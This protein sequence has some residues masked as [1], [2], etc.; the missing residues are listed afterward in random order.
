M[1]FLHWRAKPPT[2]AVAQSG[3]PTAIIV[4]AVVVL[5]AI[6]F[7]GGADAPRSTVPTAGSGPSAAPNA[8]DIRATSEMLQRRMKELQVAAEDASR[9][10]KGAVPPDLR[11]PVTGQ[12]AAQQQ[13]QDGFEIERKR[14]AL[15]L[16]K[17]R[18]LAPFA[19][20]ESVQFR[21]QQEPAP[22]TPAE[23][24]ETVQ[25]K[26]E[27]KPAEVETE[28]Q[29]TIYE[30]T[31]V[32][33]VLVN[34]LDATFSGPVKVQVAV[35]VYSRDRTRVLIPAGSIALGVLGAAGQGTARYGYDSG[36]WDYARQGAGMG[37]ANSGQ[38]VLN[39]FLNIPPTVTIREGH[40]V[41]V[42]FMQDVKVPAYEGSN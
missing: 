2:G 34:R 28:K 4:M 27:T 42:Y 1:P 3:R 21:D 32:E 29:Y 41:K 33:T 13:P 7:F 37:M 16:E 39:R 15:E 40:R 35:P 25:A 14:I 23:S 17:R 11:E 6:Y 22:Q 38:T 36:G 9:A 19:P 10:A 26:A 8:T 30:G 31:V 12:P 5:L 24:T 18:L 20:A